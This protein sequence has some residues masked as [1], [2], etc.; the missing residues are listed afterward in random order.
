M[1]DP[2][3]RVRHLHAAARSRPLGRNGRQLR[4]DEAAEGGDQRVVFE[5]QACGDAVGGACAKV[6]PGHLLAEVERSDLLEHGIVARLA[7]VVEHCAAGRRRIDVRDRPAVGRDQVGGDDVA[8]KDA[9]RVGVLQA[10]GKGAEVAGAHGAR[11]DA[12]GQQAAA[13]ADAL[14]FDAPEE[15]EAV[16][17]RGPAQREAEVV[18][19]GRPL[20]DPVQVR[21]IVVRVERVPAQVFERAAAEAIRSG[22]RRQFDPGARLPAVLRRRNRGRDGD[23]VHELGPDLDCLAVVAAGVEV[24]AA[25][26][27]DQADVLP[28]AVERGVDRQ[29]GEA[30]DGSRGG[31]GRAGDESDPVQGPASVERQRVELLSGE[32]E[33]R[34][35]GR[36]ADVDGRRFGAAHL[37]RGAA[38]Q[39]EVHDETAA[40]GQHTPR[41]RFCPEAGAFDGDRVGPRREAGDGVAAADVG[42]RHLRVPGLD[43]C[44]GDGRVGDGAS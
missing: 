8:R 33:R 1:R 25:I 37:R 31:L 32:C 29:A 23:V 24:E 7:V 27:F 21:E 42:G 10:H 39:R 14:P 28:A 13:P 2:A 18:E 5:H 9:A 15:E 41:P 35:P 30:F 36:S 34:L 26:D 3:P 44:D 12:A 43:R 38:C 19:R 6:D 20:L 16:P 11:R 4:V 22:P 40:G 17:H